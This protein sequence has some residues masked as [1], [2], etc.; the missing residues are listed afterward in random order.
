MLAFAQT[1][2]GEAPVA[3]ATA[4]LQMPETM[5]EGLQPLTAKAL[6]ASPRVIDARLK[7]LAADAREE[8]T[9]SLTRPRA[10]VFV[11]AGYRA[12]DASK[13]MAFQTYYNVSA[14]Q[15][16]W[17]W[18][19]LDNQKRVAKIQ[20]QLAAN[21]YDEARRSL[22][23][24]I[25]QRYLAL[26]LQKLYVAETDASYERLADH[27]KATREQAG[28]GQVSADVLTAEQ[29]DVRAAE[30]A[31]D[32][33]RSA[34]QRALRE[35]AVINGL[36]SFSPDGLP[37]EIPGV[38]PAML[39]L[40]T[41]EA[42]A[43]AAQVV[44]AALARAQGELTTARLNADI[45]RVRTRPMVNLAVGANQDQTSGADQTAVLSYYG[46][47]NVRWNIF[48]GFATRAAV[49]RARVVVRQNEK[50]LD[51]TRIQLTQAL[52]DGAADVVLATRE[53][54]IAEERFVQTSSRQRVDEDLRKSGRLA[55]AEWQDRRGAAQVE[56]ANL[57]KLRGQLILL[58]SEQALLR[59]R[60][61]KPSKD[62][63]FP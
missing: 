14:E 40:F 52:A 9:R 19:S 44:P 3:G 1:T 26:M 21:D 38:S 60:A 41:P 13:E 27:L 29:L 48:D 10:D 32:R 2:S 36:P 28:R 47:V 63:R 16:L 7:A 22:V 35:F 58:L 59:E 42:P 17:H 12:T 61:T 56:R 25:R 54:Q 50:A 43:P 8:E 57:V 45:T 49:R 4:L 37:S 15:P 30:V 39:A 55:E 18:N 31:R 34:F 20:R 51:E 24:D 33:K 62:I 53:L 46:G 6:E 11:N 5:I 23:L